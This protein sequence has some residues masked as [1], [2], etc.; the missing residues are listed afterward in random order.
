MR[1]L[2]VSQMYPGPGR[3]ISASSSRRSSASSRRAGTSSSARSSTGAGGD[4]RAPRRS[5]STCCATARR[6]RPDVVYAHFL[7]P[8]GLLAALAGARAARRHRPRPGRRERR[9]EPGRRAPR[10]G[11][12]SGGRTRSSRSRP[13]S[14]TGS[15]RRCRRPRRRA[16]VVD[17]GVDLERFAPRDADE[18]RAEVGW[19]PA[20]T[21]F[22]C[23]GSL[24]RAQER[25]PAGAGVRAARRGRAR[26]RR[27]RARC[28][29]RSRAR[30][31]SSSSAA[32][33]RARRRAGSPRP[34]SSASRAS[35]SRSA[36][37]R[38]RR[39][40]PAGR[41]SR[42]RSAARP[43]SCPP[44]RASSSIPLDDD[45]LVAALDEAAALPR[46]NLAARGA[47]AELTTSGCRRS[48]W[49]R[50][51]CE[52]LEIGEPELDER[53]DRVLEPRLARDL[54]RLLVALAH[55]LRRRRPA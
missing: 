28:G 50:S 19:S 6:F 34:T 1:I 46:P 9:A 8:A 43:S 52:P 12:S 20:G 16:T 55:L 18:A 37:R 13:G 30:R 53:P 31:A 26:V 25:P 47:A 45:A 2:L 42:R 29:A 49:R 23:V 21:G 14:A 3:R 44:E 27:R 4:S 22:L 32:S 11:S 39:W 24:T 36:W 51:S 33:P 5:P 15:R 7:V 38:S 54:E 35:S 40:R 10:R 17:C 41:S 48:G